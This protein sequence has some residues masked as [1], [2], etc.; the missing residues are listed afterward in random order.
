MLRMDH[1]APDSVRVQIVSVPFRVAAYLLYLNLFL[2]EHDGT[3]SSCLCILQPKIGYEYVDSI[4][5]AR[6]ILQVYAWF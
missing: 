3:E 6:M 1:P 2:H 4:T 5:A